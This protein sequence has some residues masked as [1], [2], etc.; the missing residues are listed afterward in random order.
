[1]INTYEVQSDNELSKNIR[2]L[3]K[4]EKTFYVLFTNPFDKKSDY[5]YNRILENCYNVD[6]MELD[7][8]CVDSFLCPSGFTLGSF[9]ITKT[10]ALVS[11]KFDPLFG[12]S[13]TQEEWISEIEEI[14]E[15]T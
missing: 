5:L 3:K 6:N 8:I 2:L 11:F 12:Y 10:P 4:S 9:H 7:I 15:L 14:L 13:V 1:M